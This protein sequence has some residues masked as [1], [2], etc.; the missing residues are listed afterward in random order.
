MTERKMLET[1]GTLANS[2]PIFHS[3]A[4]FQHALAWALR[5]AY[6]NAD[7]RLEWPFSDEGRHQYLDIALRADGELTAIEL[8]YRTRKLDTHSGGESF[9]LRTQAAQDGGRYDFWRDVRRLEQLVMEKK[10]KEGYA[11]LITN[12]WTFWNEGR[13]GTV[14]AAFRLHE[15][16]TRVSGSLAW[17]DHASAGTVHSRESPIVLQSSYDIHWRPYSNDSGIAGAEFKYLM[18]RVGK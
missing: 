11:V 14:D 15:G 4:D 5:E 2:R 16:R 1:L 7:V 8:K 13:E 12:D 3:E 10:A 9:E 17:T 6:P 18:L